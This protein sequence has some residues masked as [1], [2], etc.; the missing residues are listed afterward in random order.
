MLKFKIMNWIKSLF[1]KKENANINHALGGKNK[2]A[3]KYIK[4]LKSPSLRERKEAIIKLGRLRYKRAVKPLIGLLNDPYEAIRSLAVA[5]LGEIGDSRAVEPLILSLNN[6]VSG[7]IRSYT[8]GALGHIGDKVAIKP[9]LKVAFEDEDEDTR[10]D[11]RTVLVKTFNW[12][13][14]NDITIKTKS[15]CNKKWN[16]SLSYPSD[17]SEFKNPETLGQ[18][19][20][21]I[22][23]GKIVREGWLKC[24]VNVRS[25]E[26]L[27]RDTAVKKI[28]IDMDGKTSEQPANIAEYINQAREELQAIF[29][30][31]KLVSTEEI[32]ID[33]KTAVKIAYIRGEGERII[34]EEYTTLFGVGNTFLFI[35]EVPHSEMKKYQKP[36]EK[37]IDSFKIGNNIS[38]KLEKET[39]SDN[40]NEMNTPIPI[41]PEIFSN[42]ELKTEQVQSQLRQK[43]K[44]DLKETILGDA[45]GFVDCIISPNGKR[46]A[47]VMMDSDLICVTI[48]GVK[49]QQYDGIR[50]DSL[51]FSPDSIS[52][53]Y[54]AEK[55]GKWFVVNNE[56]ESMK[57]DKISSLTFSPDS[58][59]FAFVAIVGNKSVAS[60]DGEISQEYDAIESFGFKKT[61]NVY[62]P[63][64]LAKHGSKWFLNLNGN[65]SKKYER[66]GTIVSNPYTNT[67]YLDKNERNLILSTDVNYYAFYANE[68]RH[69]GNWVVVIDGIENKQV[70]DGIGNNSLIFSPDGLHYAYSAIKGD[71]WIVNID[72][73]EYGDYD[74]VSDIFF[75]PDSN[76]IVSIVKKGSKWLII[77]DGKE[78]KK[79]DGIFSGDPVFS[80][81]SKYLVFGARSENNWVYVINGYECGK[82][83]GFNDIVFSSNSKKVAIV[84]ERD[85]KWFVVINNKEGKHY[86]GIG[87][88]SLIFSDHGNHWA[89][90]VGD[91]GKYFIVQNKNEGKKYD[92]LIA[93]SLKAC[94][95]GDYFVY[96]ASVKQ[97]HMIIIGNQET[98]HYDDFLTGSPFF[99]SSTMLHAIALKNNKIVQVDINVN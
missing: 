74:N 34:Y 13:E 3:E 77:D 65:E 91:H 98:Q 72:G 10:Q 35:C 27:N 58:K 70:Y 46:N 8:A 89:Y 96:S 22:S 48:D 14:D 54:A 57:F 73:N 25:E 84:A 86:E 11:A 24:M 75:S 17:W 68:Y 92:G 97:N 38:K 83:D 30:G 1:N 21:P 79:Y 47:L 44:I 43:F 12:L 7:A 49:S 16:F 60:I 42:Q 29:P 41:I 82:Y 90:V 2:E 55:N 32:R 69:G 94:P 95:N 80:P 15:Y 71:K 20:V 9:L 85:N 18:W 23:V 36:F 53:A 28:S 76:R 87:D 50:K 31:F 26:I 4:T 51:K 61:G 99:S 66:I 93:G 59:R 40:V 67:Y 63:I 56:D 45:S 81:D 88:V 33:N 78:S 6:D 62:Q 39:S 19:Y 37:F 64:F 52:V 5:S